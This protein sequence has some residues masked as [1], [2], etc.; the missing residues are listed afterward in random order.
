MA[1]K[2][3]F[4]PPKILPMDKIIKD[5]DDNVNYSEH[6]KY[7]TDGGN[8]LHQQKQRKR[9]PTCKS[10]NGPTIFPSLDTFIQNNL[11][12]RKNIPGSIRAWTM[13]SSTCSYGGGH[14]DENSN[15]AG[16]NLS[17]SLV[18]YHMK[19]NRWCENIN[20]SHKSNNIMWNVSIR[21]GTYWQSCHDPDCR[22]ASFCGEVKAL[23]AQ[24]VSDISDVLQNAA[25]VEFEKALMELDLDTLL[26]SK[27]S[28]EISSSSPAKQHD[29]DDKNETCLNDFD[30]GENG[31]YD[32]KKFSYALSLA[33]SQNSQIFP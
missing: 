6:L 17:R 12:Q 22:M 21:D 20:R 29:D 23:P 26:S 28:T 13:E 1:N 19:D 7:C 5:D 11:G 10:Q 30:D 9:K 24:V 2:T 15:N 18:T 33:L 14:N 31:G 27:I 4:A 25:D 3:K 8:A 32:D 16:N